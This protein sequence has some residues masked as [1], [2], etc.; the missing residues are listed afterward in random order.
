[1]IVFFDL[2]FINNIRYLGFDPKFSKN[3]LFQISML[4]FLGCILCMASLGGGGGDGGDSF[5][6]FE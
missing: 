2:F 5:G 3:N 6:S 4:P 1:M